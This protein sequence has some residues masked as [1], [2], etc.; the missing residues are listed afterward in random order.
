MLVALP[1]ASCVSR[2]S[3]LAAP[4]PVVAALVPELAGM[5]WALCRQ[6]RTDRS[7][8][9]SSRPAQSATEWL[10][11][12][13]WAVLSAASTLRQM[14][15]CPALAATATMECAPFRPLGLEL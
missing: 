7:Q 15:H 1:P 5:C 12:C 14:D 4:S 2:S 13:C 11:P 8:A 3:H 10:P 6:R 9:G